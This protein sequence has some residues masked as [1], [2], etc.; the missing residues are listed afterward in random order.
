M[1]THI[2]K[3]II[4]SFISISI[5]SSL[6]S[7]VNIANAKDS[8]DEV[9]ENKITEEVLHTIESG[10]EKIPVYIWYEDINR[11]EV[12]SNV[13]N[14][15][16]FSQYD[17]ENDYGEPTSKLLNEL[18][19]AA[20]GNPDYYLQELMRNHLKLTEESRKKEKEKAD[21]Y[22]EALYD[23]LNYEY[24]NKVEKIKNE[25]E[26][27]DE[28]LLFSSK[29]TP[30][31]IAELTPSKIYDISEKEDILGIDLFENFEIE[32]C[33]IDMGNSKTEMG[34][35]DIVDQIQL[36]GDGVS[37]GIHDSGNVSNT[38]DADAINFNLD[39]SKVTLVGQI[40]A[41]GEHATYVAAVAA[42]RDGI[43]P[44]ADIVSASGNITT[45]SGLNEFKSYNA[46]GALYNLEALID[47]HVYLINCSWRVRGEYRYDSNN[48]PIFYSPFEKYIDNL[49]AQSGV[50]IV[51]ATGNEE[52]DYVGAPALAFNCISVN[53]FAGD[54]I[55]PYSYLHGDGCYKPDVVASSFA[56]GGTSTSAPVISGMIALM[57]QYKPSLRYHPEIV[58]AILIG[59]V[60]EKVPYAYGQNQPL[61][62]Y[63]SDGLTNRQGAGVPNLYRM[64]S[65]VAQH[66]YGYG[67][68]NSTTGYSRNIPIYEPKYGSSNINVS[69]A[70]LQTNVTASM[71]GSCDDYDISLSNSTFINDKVSIKARSSTEMIYTAM[72]STNNNYTLNI[73]KY[74]GTMAEVK[75]GYAWSTDN[76]KFYPSRN[77]TGIYRI[78][79]GKSD[80]YLTYNDNSNDITVENLA[81]DTSQYWIIDDG[82]S[83]FD[84]V[85]SANG[86]DE[87]IAKGNS[88]SS[89][90]YKANRAANAPYLTLYNDADGTFGFELFEQF[91][92]YRLG[93]YNNSTASGALAAWYNI[94]HSN[95]SQK[96]Y[97]EPIG[98]KCGDVNMDGEI[99]SS[100]ASLVLSYYAGLSG[101][102]ISLN[103]LQYYLADFDGDGEIDAL[104]A[105]AILAYIS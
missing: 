15:I 68:L 96:W 49:I 58:K 70:Y 21:Q 73:S 94:S 29:Y 95:L 75:Y 6:S 85:K 78:R 10:E 83:M 88:I 46:L 13:E 65:M 105:S 12:E 11:N 100:D 76:N 72:S 18:K 34:I 16:G 5:L 79:N 98:Y 74:S 61:N 63:L 60:H 48:N 30:L 7:S 32:P 52:N 24:N 19:K 31:I 33:T 20:S 40:D 17:I 57:F 67:K 56:A 89:G 26:I 25:N 99:T 93:V 38:L 51:W 92:G 82:N 8:N 42:G 41:Q 14:K 44:E 90:Y 9:I 50:T 91:N 101:G 64:I 97:L 45:L 54:T 27:S 81:N 87:N 43:A 104:D 35:S 4:S 71:P 102:N 59:S 22:I 23:E 3:K 77:E 28:D 69:M 86:T 62:E 55:S 2:F 80:K 66:S 1:N 37:I 84:Y 53:S 47:A 36:D 39:V 103:N